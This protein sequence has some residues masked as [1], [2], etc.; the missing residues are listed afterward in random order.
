MHIY[1]YYRNKIF[2][3]KKVLSAI[4]ARLATYPKTEVQN[5]STKHH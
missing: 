3:S 2:L 1:I 4:H 5:V